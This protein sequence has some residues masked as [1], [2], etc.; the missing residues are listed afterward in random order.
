MHGGRAFKGLQ[1]AGGLAAVL[2]VGIGIA[3]LVFASD[4]RAH[5]TLFFAVLTL[6]AIF[7]V[8]GIRMLERRPWLGA[9]LASLGAVLGGVAL[10]WTIAALVLAVVIVVLSVVCARRVTAARPSGP[11]RS[12]TASEHS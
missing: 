6:F 2:F 5:Q 8:A 11:D 10:F 3:E 9:G 7:V 12:G 1:I 4:S